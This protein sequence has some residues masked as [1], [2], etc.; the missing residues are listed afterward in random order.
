MTRRAKGMIG[1]LSLFVT[2]LLQCTRRVT[3]LRVDPGRREGMTWHANA[4][5]HYIRFTD[6]LGRPIAHKCVTEECYTKQTILN[7]VLKVSHWRGRLGNGVHQIAHAIFTAKLLGLEHVAIPAGGDIRHLFYLPTHGETFTISP[8]P[9]F[10]TRAKCSGDAKYY[11]YVNCTGVKRSDYTNVMRQYMLSRL[12]PQARAACDKEATSVRRELVV[13]LRSG[14]LLDA[15][16]HQAAFAPC[17]FF[18]VLINQEPR[19]ERVRIITERDRRHPCLS[20]IAKI[21]S[22][23]T[24]QS[25]TIEA[26]ACVLMHADHLALGAASTFSLALSWFNTRPVTIYDPFGKCERSEDHECPSGKQATYCVPGLE[27]VRMGNLKTNWMHGYD[28]S[29]IR[30]DGDQCFE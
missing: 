1:P 19:F 2:M 18:D 21:S 5:D 3:S 12:V 27:T 13:H 4:T 24:V 11:Y 30:K 26:D 15:H 9:E 17:S 25:K 23:V 14:D 7:G 10:R 8:D 28:Q 22:N 16:H 29:L 6:S 20:F